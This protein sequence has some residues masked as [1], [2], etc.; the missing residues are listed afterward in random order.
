MVFHV[1]VKVSAECVSQCTWKHHHALVKFT[2]IS[3]IEELT[4][5]YKN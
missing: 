1:Y 5:L 2:K 4:E 3:I